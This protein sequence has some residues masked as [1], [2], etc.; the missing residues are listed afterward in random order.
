M[1][2]VIVG[3]DQFQMRG[4]DAVLSGPATNRL[5]IAVR[6]A[7]VAVVGQFF[8]ILGR[9]RDL[10]QLIEECNR[11]GHV[12]GG[13]S[14]ESWSKTVSLQTIASRNNSLSELCP[15]P[16]GVI[17]FQHNFNGVRRPI[18]FIL[19]V[20]KSGEHEF[21]VLFG[22]VLMLE[23]RRTEIDIVEIYVELLS[24][25]LD[26]LF[27]RYHHRINGLIYV[28]ELEAGW[29]DLERIVIV[30]DNL[31][32]VRSSFTAADLVVI[33]LGEVID[34]VLR[35]VLNLQTETVNAQIIDCRVKQCVLVFRKHFP[36]VHLSGLGGR[37]PTEHGL[38]SRSRIESDDW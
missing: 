24:S 32:P 19:Q 14:D 35:V 23:G 13:W 4:P 38:I 9:A 5:Q 10:N 2:I 33:P 31:I 16:S 20:Q 17:G 34:R 37:L 6:D 21:G 25:S 18:I 7:A 30:I 11:P 15:A 27:N 12:S 36:E 28:A 3:P 8:N 1:Q 26:L 22:I 29:V